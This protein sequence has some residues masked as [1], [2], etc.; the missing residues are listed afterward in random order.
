MKKV[1]TTEHLRKEERR[2]FKAVWIFAIGSVLSILL[3][4]STLF[5]SESLTV[6]TFRISDIVFYAVLAYVTIFTLLYLKVYRKVDFKKEG[7]DLR[8]HLQIKK[9]SF[10]KL[11]DGSYEMHHKLYLKKEMKKMRREGLSTDEITKKWKEQL[12]EDFKRLESFIKEKEA[13]GESVVIHTYTH[14]RMYKTWIKIAR[15]VGLFFEVIEDNNQKPVGFKWRE[16]KKG[17]YRTS[18]KKAKKDS[19]PKANEWNKYVLTSKD[20]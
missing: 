4:I 18:G 14:I 9:L 10:T 1:W 17:V 20:Q 6:V 15:D 19:I 12:V 16:W 13:K 8:E 3:M 2:W 7:K 11:N 5:L